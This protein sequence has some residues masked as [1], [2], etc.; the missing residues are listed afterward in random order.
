MDDFNTIP[1][2]RSVTGSPAADHQVRDANHLTEYAREAF[3]RFV[4]GEPRLTRLR[5]DADGALL[6]AILNNRAGLQDCRFAVNGELLS[7]ENGNYGCSDL[8]INIPLRVMTRRYVLTVN[9]PW[10][11]GQPAYLRLVAVDAKGHTAYEI[12]KGDTTT[13]LDRVAYE[14]L[15][16]IHVH[17]TR[18]ETRRTPLEIYAEAAM[19]EDQE[20]RAQAAEAQAKQQA[21]DLA[22]Q[23]EAAR[24]IIE[25]EFPSNVLDALKD[26]GLRYDERSTQ[27][28]GTDVWAFE[29]NRETYDLVAFRTHTG[30]RS[31][32]LEKRG[33]RGGGD[34]LET[35]EG[36]G[37][38]WRL[39]L[40]RLGEE[41]ATT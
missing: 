20:R 5:V 39:M 21:A 11:G 12:L 19:R 10:E 9:V 34:I 32:Q 37:D 8:A 31:W 22:K 25:F 35:W 33:D 40:V 41:A 36:G 3:E 6:A 30:T 29:F 15:R 38:G 7:A 14:L 28:A 27:I 13:S 24:A 17:D 2:E 18:A 1:C 16:D 4:G 23:E 26:S